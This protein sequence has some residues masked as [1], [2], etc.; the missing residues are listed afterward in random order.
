M[1]QVALVVL[2]VLVISACGQLSTTSALTQGLQGEPGPAGSP[3]PSGAD[4][5]TATVNVG[6]NK[7]TGGYMFRYHV[8]TFSTGDVLVSCS[9]SDSL[10]TSS[11]SIY[12]RST[13]VGASTKG[14][15]VIHDSSGA[16]TSGFW[17]F[18]TESTR[19]ATY[20]DVGSAIDGTVITFADSDCTTI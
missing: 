11:D 2:G 4:G 9:V 10:Y 13:Q 6:C 17:K 5:N 3:G 7:V 15:Q 16:A 19:T 20:T 18:K 8:V 12:Y 14:C 1:K